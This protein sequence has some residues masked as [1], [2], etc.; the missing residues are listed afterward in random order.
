[1]NDTSDDFIATYRKRIDTL[2]DGERLLRGLRMF[3]D[4]K[5]LIRAGIRYDHPGMHES[6]VEKLLFLRLYEDELPHAAV[7][8]ALARI[9]EQFVEKKSADEA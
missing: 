4:G 5:A 9:E 3:D 8:R 1:M 7:E 6:E 2:T